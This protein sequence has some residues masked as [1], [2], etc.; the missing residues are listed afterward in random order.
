MAKHWRNIKEN[1]DHYLAIGITRVH[2]SEYEGY[3]EFP[4]ELAEEV[5][6]GGSHRLD[7]CTT[8][9]FSTRVWSNGHAITLSWFL[10]LET[11]DANY[12]SEYKIDRAK[13]AGIFPL[14]RR[15]LQD[16]LR[17]ILTKDAELIRKRADEFSAASAR[18]YADAALFEQLAKMEV[19]P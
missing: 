1:A 15:E 16:Q 8:L 13:I 17:E 7:I 19:Q 12:S 10:D 9:R 11:R 4:W 14:L 18:Q 2:L 5:E 3:S 6:E